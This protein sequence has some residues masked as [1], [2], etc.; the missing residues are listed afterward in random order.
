MSWDIFILGILGLSVIYSFVRGAIRE[1]FSF[2]ALIAGYVVATRVYGYGAPYLDWAASDRKLTGIISF[3]AVFLTISLLVGAL[4]RML[5]V[6]ARKAHLSL[7]NRT[8]GA[9]FGLLKGVV[10]VSILLLLSPM[11][12]K[13]A[14]QGKLLHG[15]ILAPFFDAATEA[16]SSV[17]PTKKYGPLDNRL[18]EELREVR[19][20][21]GLGFWAD[22]SRLIER[23]RGGAPA[24]SGQTEEEERAIRKLIKQ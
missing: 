23:K 20:D 12:S 10:L 7:V 2:L 4:G 15:S 24:N 6:A 3:V 21:R 18:S 16:L 13:A 9:L 8:F 19:N 5:H 22:L 1:V 14:S 11:F 17:F